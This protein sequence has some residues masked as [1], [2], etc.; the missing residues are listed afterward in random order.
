V[1][2]VRREELR[3]AQDQERC[4]DVPQL[5]RRNPGQQAAEPPVHDRPDPDP[6]RLPLVLAQPR[7]RPDGRQH[8]QSRQ[9]TR[10][11]RDEDRRADAHDRDEGEREQRSH[12]RA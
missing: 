12:D 10:N 1:A 11:H 3:R 4:G 7:R 9:Q 5:E 6:E 8:R 2:A